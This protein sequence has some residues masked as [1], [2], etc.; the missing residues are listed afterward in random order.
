MLK[1]I[2]S[3]L[4]T[5]ALILSA[6]SAGA[7][8]VNDC[9]LSQLSDQD[10]QALASG[11]SLMKP[12]FSK[13]NDLFIIDQMSFVSNPSLFEA[14]ANF[15]NLLNYLDTGNLIDQTVLSDGEVG[16]NNPALYDVIPKDNNPFGKLYQPFTLAASVHPDREAYQVQFN[17][18]TSPNIVKHVV[19]DVCLAK[20]NGK[21]FVH[22]TSTVNG[23][24]KLDLNT[25]G[26]G[27]KERMG[28]W[29]AIFLKDLERASKP[30]T[31]ESKTNLQKALLGNKDI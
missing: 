25:P 17:Y 30:A 11:G 8:T 6:V 13:G 24:P 20:V 2:K 14:T 31:D 1:Q 19:N 3:S 12:D 9:G 5:S 28:V 22:F 26:F 7:K 16:S 29:K 15:F 18:L 27:A 23:N 4:I 10:Q 21:V